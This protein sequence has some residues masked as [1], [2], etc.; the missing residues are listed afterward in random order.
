M[1]AL[2]LATLLVSLGL[3]LGEKTPKVTTKLGIIRG[4]YKISNNGNK[5]KA[6][7]GVPYALPPVGDKRFEVPVS[8]EPWTGELEANKVKRTCFSYD[9]E[10][11][12]LG[13]YL[14]GTED[15]LYMNIYAPM[16]RNASLPVLV[17]IHGGAFQYGTYM[18]NE[19]YYLIDHDVIY[20]AIN[21]RLGILGFLSTEDDIVP[22]NMG[23]KDQS[24]ALRWIKENI[25]SFGGDP[26][27]I[28]ITGLSAGGASV[29]YHYMSPLSKGLFQNGISFSGTAFN[30]W[31]QTENSREKAIKLGSL[32]GCPTEDV[33]LMVQCLKEIPARN[34]T[35]AVTL[36][37]PWQ[38]MPFTPFGPV[39]E[40]PSETAFITRSP[41]EILAS[42]E[43]YDVPWITGVVS[44]EGL[45]P[46]AEFAE[47]DTVLRDLDA[48]WEELAPILLDFNYTLPEEEHPMTAKRIR[49]FYF[50]DRPI[51]RENIGILIDLSSDRFFSADAVKVA[52]IHATT[53]QS[54]VWFYYYSHRA[55]NSLSEGTLHNAHDYGV[56][57]GDDVYMVLGNDEIIPSKRQ[58]DLAVQKIL[59]QLWTS[60]AHDRYPK[61]EV[62]W[63]KV[64]SVQG[65]L[66]EA[67]FNFL[68]IAGP[69][70]LNQNHSIEFIHTSF[71]SSLGLD[72]NIVKR[73][74]IME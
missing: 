55:V 18:E 38:L 19:A 21:Y 46:I 59:I 32:M 43:Y 54:P 73:A 42:G 44:E 49:E 57:H 6:F 29:H 26:N 40:K 50:G 15:C 16:T 31:A 4:H 68:H 28:T 20:V 12:P 13:K 47:N 58:E 41:A 64:D 63:S 30:C 67:N 24:L 65:K 35:E 39:I 25:E 72:E 37:M 74:H 27:R 1:Y 51:N 48:N 71:W 69:D 56:C 45:Y 36:F 60:V 70:Q 17:Y 66:S 34:L 23:L 9:R 52:K 2:K 62:E 53:S 8:I 22:G 61:L 5:Y 33:A 7:E 11:F 3:C 10:V 14:D